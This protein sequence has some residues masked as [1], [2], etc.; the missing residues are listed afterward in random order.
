M[1]ITNVRISKREVEGVHQ[2]RTLYGL[3]SKSNLG[4]HARP[5]A[6]L[7]DYLSCS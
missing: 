4:P 7:T 3:A 1:T 2:I 5:S 6:R